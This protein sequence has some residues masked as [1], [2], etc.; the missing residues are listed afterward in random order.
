MA[1]AT[2]RKTSSRA[3]AAAARSGSPAKAKAAPPAPTK[4]KPLSAKQASTKPATTKPVAKK[5]ASAKPASAKPAA[6]KAAAAKAPPAKA[7]PRPVP[8][9]PPRPAKPIE[10]YYWPTANGWKVS[11]MLEECGVPYVLR[12]VNIGRGEQFTADYLK[13]SPNGRI[14]AIADPD[15]PG[16]KEISV[17]ESGA[18]LQYLGRKTGKFYPADERGRV[19]VDEW[20]FWQVSGLG[21]MAGQ[22]N[23][24]RQ[25]A[26]ETIPYAIER[27]TNEVGRLYNVMNRRLAG[28]DYLAG[29]YSIADIACYG[30]IMSHQQQGQNLA[31]FVHLK[32]WFDR[33]GA[34]PGVQRGLAVGRELRSAS[35]SDLRSSQ[36]SRR[37]LLN[38]KP[39]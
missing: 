15:G 14:P 38:Q 7:A 9:P 35:P 30:W 3:G 8:A 34:R 21:P 22:A 19:A 13:I 29:P 4:A 36:D 17:F 10:F 27:Y 6:A 18:V 32:A 24:F 1:A 37:V 28:R 26:P 31:A 23:H 12:P 16:G 20:L 39:R 5:Q 11:I 25:F 33:V 2:S